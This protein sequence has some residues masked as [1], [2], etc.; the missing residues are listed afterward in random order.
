VTW[1]PANPL[2]ASGGDAH[3][4]PQRIDHVFL[5]RELAEQAA[6]AS[7]RVVFAE[8]RVQTPRGALPLSDHYAV[9]AELVARRLTRPAPVRPP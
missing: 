2:V 7:A 1:D 8:R 6:C 4:P 3:L 5:N 9:R